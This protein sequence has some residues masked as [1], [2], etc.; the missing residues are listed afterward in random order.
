M[1]YW[2]CDRCQLTAFTLLVWFEA[3]PLVFGDI[4]HMSQGVASLP[5]LGTVSTILT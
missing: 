3:F 4:Y 5:F 2:D 1:F